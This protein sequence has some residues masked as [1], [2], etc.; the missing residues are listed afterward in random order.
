MS[1]RPN[2]LRVALAEDR[3]V[4]GAFIWS[5]ATSV[6]EAFGHIGYDYVVIDAE[7]TAIG[8]DYTEHLIR[9]AETAGIV[10]IVRVAQL[11]RAVIVRALDS[12]AAG[13]IVPQIHTAQEAQYAVQAAKYHP[14]GRRGMAQ[15]RAAG[16]GL[17]VD[18]TYYED[19]NRETLFI[20]QVE[21]RD[22]VEHLPSILATPGIDA[23]LIGPLDL[24]Q[25][26]GFPG[27]VDVPAVRTV[28]ER[29]IQQT[30]AA[31]LPVGIIVNDIQSAR[32]WREHG[33]R[34]IL[35]G[36]D[37]HFMAQSATLAL[38]AWRQE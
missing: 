10:P 4:L 29:V 2:P 26:F 36:T 3:A 11:D 22:A 23:V 24:S 13:V 35:L 15:S 18:D 31:H 28:T 1:I 20:V 9:A 37:L 16:F 7:H 17:K 19:A 33:C 38:T 27:Q 32:Y 34:L 14:M 12:G 6:V 21:N 30:Q 8:V 25:S 5:R